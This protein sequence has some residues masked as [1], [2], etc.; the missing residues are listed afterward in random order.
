MFSVALTFCVVSLGPVVSGSAL[1]EHKV[2]RPEDL[3]KRSGPEEKK[4]FT[5][6]VPTQNS[7]NNQPTYKN[8]SN[9]EIIH[10]SLAYPTKSI[11]NLTQKS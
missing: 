11:V 8:S 4:L 1:S 6:T 2:V 5:P 7:F 9:N 3:A 10:F